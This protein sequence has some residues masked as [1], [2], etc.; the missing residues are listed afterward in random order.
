M[1]IFQNKYTF[2]IQDTI[3]NNNK[4]ES[5]QLYSIVQQNSLNS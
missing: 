1:K 3:Q 4:F 2:S 5:F